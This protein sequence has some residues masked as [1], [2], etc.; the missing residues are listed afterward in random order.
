MGTHVDGKNNK[1]QQQQ[2]LLLSPDESAPSVVTTVVSQQQQVS[3]HNNNNNNKNRSG[4]QVPVV[5]ETRS[6]EKKA[7]ILAVVAEAAQVSPV[8]A[9]E[10]LAVVTAATEITV[11]MFEIFISGQNKN[12]KHV[13]GNYNCKSH[14]LSDNR[15]T[16]NFWDAFLTIF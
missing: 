5:V 13:D 8:I 6:Q 16:I 15:C 12:L 14:N 7:Q 10:I 2:L 9:K 4:Q 1:S 11:N 3:P